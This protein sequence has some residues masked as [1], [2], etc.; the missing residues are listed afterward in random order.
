MIS[1]T[2]AILDAT[3]CVGFG[4]AATSLARCR[5]ATRSSSL[6]TPVP[7]GGGAYVGYLGWNP[8]VFFCPSTKSVDDYRGAP[9]LNDGR[10][11]DGFKYI[12]YAFNGVNRS[13]NPRAI[14]LEL[15]LWEGYVS[16]SEEDAPARR[17]STLPMPAETILLQDAWESLLDGNGDIPTDEYQWTSQPARLREWYR[18]GSRS[19][20][21]MWADG[22]ASY[23]KEG[24]IHWEEAW[25]IG[26]PLRSP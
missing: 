10:F 18:H 2:A 25:Y 7:I 23:E 20:N 19:T 8:G 26:R 13:R 17:V 6:G 1:T 11:K 16:F 22:H 14:G 5:L 3:G 24:E 4:T 12:T 15:A 9:P 21:L